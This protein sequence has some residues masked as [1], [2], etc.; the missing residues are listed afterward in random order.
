MEEVLKSEPKI[1]ATTDEK[2]V[3]ELDEL[4][5]EFPPIKEGAL[6]SKPESDVPNIV[7]SIPKVDIVAHDIVFGSVPNV[8]KSWVSLFK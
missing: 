1:F 3:F 8:E 4:I 6:K 5:E 7:F 2:N